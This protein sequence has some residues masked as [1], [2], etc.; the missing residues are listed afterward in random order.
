MG[1]EAET[2]IP[3]GSAD[4]SIETLRFH[5][6]G[7]EVHAHDDKAGLKFTYKGRRAF[8][9]GMDRMIGTLTHE[10]GSTPFVVQGEDGAQGS[11]QAADLLFERKKDGWKPRL[12]PKGSRTTGVRIVCDK[13]LAMLDDFIHRI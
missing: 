11:R 5:A 3:S 1:G 4:A 8:S 2:K 9:L 6:S 12:V 13:N 10:E 7:D